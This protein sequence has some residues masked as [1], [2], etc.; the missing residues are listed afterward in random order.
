[1]NQE[2]KIAIVGCGAGGGTAAQFARKTDRKASVTVFEKGVYPQ[3]SKCGLPY[4]ISGKIPRFEDLIEF[5]EEWF[6]KAKIDLF[7]RTNVEEIDAD[8]KIIKVNNNGKS[9][10]HPFTSIILAT[11]AEPSIP[12]IKNLSQGGELVKGVEIVRT[13]DDAKKIKSLLKPEKKATVIGAGLIGLEMAD[14]LYE[15]KIKVTVVESLPDILSNTLDPDMSAQIKDQIS[16]NV[17]IYL[18]HFANEIKHENGAI[19]SVNI[20]DRE[21]GA[22]KQ[23]PTDLLIIATGTKPKT[24]LAKKTGCMLGKHG[25]IIVNERSETSIKNLYAVGDCTEYTDFLTKKPVPIGLGSVVVRQAIAAG[26]NAAGGSYSLPSGVLQTRTT[27]IFG[28]E[29]AAVGPTLSCFDNENIVTGKF[30]GSS[31]PEYF[32]GGKPITIKVFVNAES[33]EIISAQAVGDKAAQRIN[34]LACAVLGKLQID[35]FKK[36]ETAYAPPVAPILD[37]VT[38]A[39]DVV[40]MKLNRKKR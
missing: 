1:M 29:I 21:S 8:D 34:T 2:R 3:Y 9:L 20:Q 18:N 12:P 27:S 22:I 13:I 26:I 37:A 15:K 30:N 10:E 25:H 39:C 6:N 31:L 40:S 11:G 19:K 36:L 5:S 14:C 28:F 38:L 16:E 24:S 4:A 23:I 33:G 35:L 32:P 17:D 7:L